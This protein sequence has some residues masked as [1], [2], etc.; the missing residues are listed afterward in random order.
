MRVAEERSSLDS[1]LVNCVDP[2]PLVG[3]V[4]LFLFEDLHAPTPRLMTWNTY[5]H[6]EQLGL[7]SA[8]RQAHVPRAECHQ[9]TNLSPFLP[10]RFSP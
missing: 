3:R 7:N 8:F 4:V 6:L 5:F 1:P 10:R 2:A 9:K